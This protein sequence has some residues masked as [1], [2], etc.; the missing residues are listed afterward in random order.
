M[1]LPVGSALVVGLAEFLYLLAE[2]GLACEVLLLLSAEI[3]EVLLVAFIDYGRCSLEACPYLLAQLLSY[4]SYLAV[5]LV[6]LLKL[7]ESADYVFLVGELL[8]CLA[9]LCLQLEVLLE[10]VLASLR[11][12]LE[13]VVELL[14]I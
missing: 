14:N 13:Q 6:Q 4:R 1:L 2:G 10:V 9:E 7:V 11:V 5:L 3:L 12:E 8:C